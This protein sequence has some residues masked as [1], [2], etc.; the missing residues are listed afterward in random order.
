MPHSSSISLKVAAFATLAAAFLLIQA[1][2]F[3]LAQTPL[4]KAKD[5]SEPTVTTATYGNWILRCVKAGAKTQNSDQ[6]SRQCEIVQTIQVQGQRQPIAQIALGHQ[7]GKK[8]LTLTT[9][10]P[11]NISLPGGVFVAAKAVKGEAP[12]GVVALAW[13]RCFQGSCLA[14]A[15]L[16]PE[17]LKQF[18]QETEAGL[19]G[20]VE[21]SGR[22]ISIPLSWNGLAAATTAL[23]NKE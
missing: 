3:A 11:V 4:P 9:V 20:F 15:Q 2:S 19:L 13:Q 7:P 22:T 5:Q 17:D 21:A 8:E 1:S 6:L 23:E 10:L 14:N 16:K 12:T 18:Q